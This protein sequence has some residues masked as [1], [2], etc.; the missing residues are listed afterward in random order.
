MVLGFAVLEGARSTIRF[1]MSVEALGIL[2]MR[3]SLLAVRG[4]TSEMSKLSAK[5][6]PFLALDLFGSVPLETSC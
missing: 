2:L 6:T 5:R 4:G 3:G 1:A